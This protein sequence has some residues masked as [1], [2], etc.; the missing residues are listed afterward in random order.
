LVPMRPVTPCI[1][2]PMRRSPIGTSWCWS[3]RR[4]ARVSFLRPVQD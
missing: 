4:Q 1:M 2:I 3:S